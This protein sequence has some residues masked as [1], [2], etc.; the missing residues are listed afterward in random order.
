MNRAGLSGH[1]RAMLDF[2]DSTICCA[3]HIAPGD[4]VTLKW[5]IR[6]RSWARTTKTNSTLND[7]VG[8]V[9][10][11]MDTRSFAWLLR[12]ARHDGDGGLRRTSLPVRSHPPAT[13][14]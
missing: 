11:S 5:T 3:V 7:T 9:K 4:S 6:L 14:A 13:D 1:V 12:N 8:T 2:R 10:K